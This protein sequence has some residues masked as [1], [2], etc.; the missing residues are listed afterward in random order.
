MR[1]YVC[2]VC[3]N[4]VEMIEGD[5]KRLRCCGKEMQ[6]MKASSAG[7]GAVKHLPVYEVH[8]DRIVVTVGEKIHPME[9]DH[10][11]NW[12]ALISHDK[13]A[14]KFLEPGE[15]PKAA[16]PYIKGSEIYAYCNKHD[17]WVTKVK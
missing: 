9:E 11:I 3:G 6:L 13:V 12:I 4:V 10:L 2:P 1:F 16:F 8:G 17:L 7:E 5:A 15:E 14:K